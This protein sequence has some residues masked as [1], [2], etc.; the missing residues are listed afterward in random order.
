MKTLM[1]GMLFVM[2]AYVTSADIYQWQDKNG[3]W[4]FTSMPPENMSGVIIIKERTGTEKN[5]LIPENEYRGEDYSEQLSEKHTKIK[6]SAFDLW[7][8]WNNKIE[9]YKNEL[10]SAKQDFESAKKRKDE[11]MRYYSVVPYFPSHN[12]GWNYYNNWRPSFYKDRRV[13]IDNAEKEIKVKEAFY[14]DKK[15][16]WYFLGIRLKDTDIPYRLWMD[17][18]MSD[19]FIKQLES[20]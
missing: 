8:Y 17:N 6:Q 4:N 20:E 7:D 1:I 18:F 9:S 11:V 15:K 5:N 10:I 3:V 19:A 13:A 2:F 14:N 16:S 12:T